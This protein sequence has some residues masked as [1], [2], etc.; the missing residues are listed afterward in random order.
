MST[1]E[2][3]DECGKR[4]AEGFIKDGLCIHCEKTEKEEFE[5]KKDIVNKLSEK[6][7]ARGLRRP[8]C[9]KCKEL[10]DKFENKK[11][12]LCPKCYKDG[13]NIKIPETKNYPNS[14]NHT[15]YENPIMG[16]YSEHGVSLTKIKTE[17]RPCFY[18]DSILFFYYGKGKLKCTNCEK[19]YQI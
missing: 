15:Q 16:V 2:E 13:G 18:C 7:F 4:F 17:P 11:S 6:R 9:Y 14:R 1:Y 8:R 3:C 19:E 10:Y 5:K 12:H